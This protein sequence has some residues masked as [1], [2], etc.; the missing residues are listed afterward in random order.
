MNMFSPRRRFYQVA[1][2][3]VMVLVAFLIYD[4]V[5]NASE[6][7][8]VIRRYDEFRAVVAGGEA[9]RIMQ[10]VAPEFRAWAADRLHMYRLARPLDDRATVSI[11]GRGRRAQICASP[12]RHFLIIPGGDVITMVKRDGEWYM[13]RVFID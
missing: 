6:R 12:K 4:Q 11:Y 8:R 13:G 3:L 9:G 2:V 5:V 1:S 7:Q 10:F